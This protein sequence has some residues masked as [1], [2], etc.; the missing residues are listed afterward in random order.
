MRKVRGVKALVD[1]LESISCPIGQSTI[2]SLM[3]TNRI[4]FSRPA[5]RVLLFD[6]DDIDSWLGGES[7]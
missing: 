1:Y 2:Y 3:R 5:P 7:K 6:L 4:P